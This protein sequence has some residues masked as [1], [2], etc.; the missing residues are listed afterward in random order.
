MPATLDQKWFL[1]RLSYKRLSQRQL[2]KSLGVHPSAISLMLKGKRRIQL[3]EAT[4]IAS[5]LGTPIDALLDAAGLEIP[6][7]NR[8]LVPVV[9]WVDRTGEVH[10]NPPEG[11]KRVNRPTGMP[12]G[13]AALR[14]L[15][16]SPM[17]GWIIYYVESDLVDPMAVGRWSIAQTVGGGRYLAV[18]TRSYDLEKWALTHVTTGKTVDRMKVKW[19]CP[20]VWVK[21]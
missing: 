13:T 10:T 8:S 7:E 5:V 3:H 4:E 18:L 20:V 2:A 19:A 6:R 9:G 12:D 21:S 14:I 11:P 1:D 17:H 16:Q 15:D